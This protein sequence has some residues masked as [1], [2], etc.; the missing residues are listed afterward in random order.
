MADQ[1]QLENVEYLN[2][3][4]SMKNA[5]GSTGEIKSRIATAKAAFNKKTLFSQANQLKFKEEASEMLHLEHIFTL[6]TLYCSDV[7]CL[8]YCCCVLLF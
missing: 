3:F 4:G 8:L 5:A 1:K 6:Y 2:Y 7:L